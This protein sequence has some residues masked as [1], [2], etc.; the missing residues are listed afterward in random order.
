MSRIAHSSSGAS[1]MSDKTA[2][3]V[4]IFSGRARDACEAA[5]SACMR[6]RVCP[7]IGARVCTRDWRAFSRR[8]NRNCFSRRSLNSRSVSSMRVTTSRSGNPSAA[9][10][11]ASMSISCSFMAHR[12]AHIAAGIG[13]TF[14][15]YTIS[16]AQAVD[17][18]RA[19]PRAYVSSRDS[20]H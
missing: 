19:F 2:A 1:R 20:Y 3:L 4:P 12:V 13:R 16:F 6:N 17:N 8:I 7:G 14:D 18:V 15:M 11:H 10:S 5:C 9:S